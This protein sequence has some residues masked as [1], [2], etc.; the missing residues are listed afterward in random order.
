M[1]ALYERSFGHSVEVKTRERNGSLTIV[2]TKV[3]SLL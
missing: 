3:R 2:G 1:W